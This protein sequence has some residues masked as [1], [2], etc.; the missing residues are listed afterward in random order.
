MPRC[1][2]LIS[3]L[4]FQN[5][6]FIYK[7][8]YKTEILCNFLFNFLRQKTHKVITVL[9]KTIHSFTKNRYRKKTTV[10]VL[11]KKTKNPS[12]DNYQQPSG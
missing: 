11:Q 5:E 9:T 6:F 10:I 4:L 12:G 3:F 7:A 1:R 2:N 8:K